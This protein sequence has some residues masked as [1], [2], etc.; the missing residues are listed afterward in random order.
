MSQSAPTR[1]APSRS[2][3]PDRRYMKQ[4]MDAP[5]LERQQELDLA[6]AWKEK[7][8]EEALHALTT[9]Y[10]RLVISIAAKFRNYGLPFPDLV[11]EGNIGLMQAAA[12]FEP[13][14]EVR[15]STYATW[16]IR[17]SIQDY[18]L[19]NWSIV[20][21]GTTAA[22]KSLFFNLRRLRALIKDTSSGALTPENRA[23][24][25]QALRVGEDDVEKMASR[26]A[27]VDRSLNAPFTED[28]EGEWQDLLQ[29][30][31]PNPETQVME[32]RD[33]NQRAQWLGQALGRLSEREQLII[34]ERRLG[35]DSV[36]LEKLGE[37]LGISKERVRQVEHQALKKLKQYL[38]EVVGDPEEAGLIPTD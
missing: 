33:Q 1:S 24:V 20:R 34:R 17:A 30:D 21:T 36:T 12:R 8:D 6:T 32:G 26:L 27:A 23:Y 7:G 11:S 37:R 25:A 15:F 3:D 18:V 38:T 10:M 2:V 5:L 14:R 35:E 31:N 22:Q 9:A 4:A 16:W 29:D 13:E 28:G 19:R